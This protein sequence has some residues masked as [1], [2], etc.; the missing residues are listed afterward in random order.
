MPGLL[1]RGIGR[2]FVV[3]GRVIEA[4]RDIDL[5]VPSGIMLAVVGHSGCGKTTL[6]RQIA[7]LD[8]PDEGTLEFVGEDGAVLTTFRVGMVFQEARLLPWKTVLR[9]LTLGLRRLCSKE[10][11]RERALAALRMV[12]LLNYSEAWP[13]QL[14]G[15]MAQRVALARALCRDPEILL[16]DEPFGALDALTRT[17]LH[18]EF[19]EIRAKRPFT[20]ILVT[21]DISEAVRLADEVAIMKAGR[22]IHRVSVPEPYPRSFGCA[23]LSRYIETI[24]E[25]VLER[26]GMPEK[27]VMPL[28]TNSTREELPCLST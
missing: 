20:A 15:G 26:N 24:T 7:G 3:D 10:E 5:S 4:L 11:A 27:P 9:N 2:R 28:Q 22:I 13:H 16:L 25:L 12:G 8:Y 6:L 14:S 18:E 19:M 21:H 17:R 23:S 1:L